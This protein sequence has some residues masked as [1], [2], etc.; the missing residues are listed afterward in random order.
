[1]GIQSNAL[2]ARNILAHYRNLIKYY[3][4]FVIY[5]YLEHIEL[6]YH[7]DESES[8]KVNI[9][10]KSAIYCIN[11]FMYIQKYINCLN[12]KNENFFNVK[13]YR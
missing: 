2:G 13:L 3:Y 8:S 6:L 12:E 4:V 11:N 1:M 9:L 5:S 7:K 10:K